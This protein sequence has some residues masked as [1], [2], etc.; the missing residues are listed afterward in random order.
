MGWKRGK[1]PFAI[2]YVC[3]GG[4]EGKG[5]EGNAK[6]GY[7]DLTHASK[8][9]QCTCTYINAIMYPHILHAHASTSA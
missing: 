9:I 1:P 3:G 4:G 8:H 7:I 6:I 2:A 5:Q